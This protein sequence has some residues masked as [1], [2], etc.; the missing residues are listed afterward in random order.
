[1]F[2]KVH[3]LTDT[4]ICVHVPVREQMELVHVKNVIVT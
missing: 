3:V 4:D 2:T 1:M